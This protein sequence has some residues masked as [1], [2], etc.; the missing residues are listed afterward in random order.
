M[1]SIS[2]AII[3][4]SSKS[5]PISCFGILNVCNSEAKDFNRFLLYQ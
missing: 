5:N 1:A 3:S 2:F 4:H